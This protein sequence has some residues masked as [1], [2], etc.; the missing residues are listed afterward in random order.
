M[1]PAGLDGWCSRRARILCRLIIRS[2]D[3][4]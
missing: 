4:G 2:P 1:N 3:W